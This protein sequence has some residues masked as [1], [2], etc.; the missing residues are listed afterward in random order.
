[1][2]LEEGAGVEIPPL[3]LL[4]EAEVAEFPVHRIGVAAAPGFRLSATEPELRMP[5]TTGIDESQL[6]AWRGSRTARTFGAT[7]QLS[8]SRSLEIPLVPIEP[9]VNTSIRQTLTVRPA[10]VNWAATL[11]MRIRD[12]P[13][14]LHRLQIDPR[15]NVRQVSVI[16]ESVERLASWSRP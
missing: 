5:A 13:L 4:V 10:T 11:Q 3:P 1:I 8:S 16:Q 12:A 15:V 7:Y 14:A 9:S 6:P 2:R